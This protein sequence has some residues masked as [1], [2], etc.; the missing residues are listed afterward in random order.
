MFPTGSYVRSPMYGLG[1]VACPGY[2]PLVRFLDGREE[3]IAADSLAAVSMD[4]F[5]REIAN[6]SRI[7]AWLLIRCGYP[8]LLGEGGTVWTRDHEGLWRTDDRLDEEPRYQF[9][10]I[11]C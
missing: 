8:E 9:E 11:V 6:R 1:Q 10:N 5:E 7:E 3:R 4:V 2:L